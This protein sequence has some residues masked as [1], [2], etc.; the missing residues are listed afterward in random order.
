MTVS[1]FMG[2]YLSAGV[3]PICSVAPVT[4][5]AT[6]YMFIQLRCPTLRRRQEIFQTF[7]GCRGSAK[8]PD[9]LNP[10]VKLSL[11]N[12]AARKLAVNR[13]HC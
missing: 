8:L 1:D 6:D 10:S 11:R 3:S 7:V 2:R 13:W 4:Q 9:A 5:N 12:M